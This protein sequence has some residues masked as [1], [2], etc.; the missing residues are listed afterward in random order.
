MI[1]RLA[2]ASVN[3]RYRTIVVWLAA[4]IGVVGLG[5]M[6]TSSIAWFVIAIVGLSVGVSLVVVAL[7]GL[8]ILAAAVFAGRLIGIVERARAEMFLGVK[9]SPPP[10]R[11]RPEGTWPACAHY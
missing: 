1:E 11:V 3:H 6:I 4:V 9:V 2:S 5:G 7:V 10:A 8:V